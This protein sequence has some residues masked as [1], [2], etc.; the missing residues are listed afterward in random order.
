MHDAATIVRACLGR[1]QAPPAQAIDAV[2]ARAAD[3]GGIAWHPTGFVVATLHQCDAGAL[4]LHVWPAERRVYGAPL[5]P[6]HDHAWALCSLVLVGEVG[7]AR[8]EVRPDAAGRYRRY[9]VAY[10]HERRSRLIAEPTRVA[11]R[12]GPMQATGAGG[13]YTLAA[14]EFHAS[15]VAKG[16]L[17]ATLVATQTQTQGD[18][19]PFV[20]GPADGPAT[21]DVQR[22]AV[23]AE[24]WRALLGCVREAVAA[25]TRGVAR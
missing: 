18:R 19:R 12:P 16:Q 20:L 6:I 7:S 17:A 9:A 1:G 14:G 15:A 10:G 11:G 23:A 13:I 24:R 8:M 21:V 5:W 22:P 2:V 4:R 25:G 3:V